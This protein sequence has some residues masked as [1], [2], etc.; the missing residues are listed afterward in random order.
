MDCKFDNNITNVKLSW[1]LLLY[2]G[3]VEECLCF[4]KQN[5]CWSIKGLSAIFFQM[6]QENNVYLHID[7]KVKVVTSYT[8]IHCIILA[9]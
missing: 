4:S 9:T 6:I 8:A 3:Y 2:C 5:T 7:D 1:V